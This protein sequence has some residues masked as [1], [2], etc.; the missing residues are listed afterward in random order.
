MTIDEL[1]SMLG[2]PVED[3][4]R[5][6]IIEASLSRCAGRQ[7]K[8]VE[9]ARE[10]GQLHAARAERCKTLVARWEARHG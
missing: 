1:E 10:L 2:S 7:A 4:E 5:I 9:R 3:D 8:L 6:S